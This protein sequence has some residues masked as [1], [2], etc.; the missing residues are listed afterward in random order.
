RTCSTIAST[1]EAANL[2]YLEN[3][4]LP[5]TADQEQWKAEVSS[6]VQTLI[7]P[8]PDVIVCCEAADKCIQDILQDIRAHVYDVRAF[9]VLEDDTISTALNYAALQRMDFNQILM[10][11]REELGLAGISQSP[12]VMALWTCP[13]YRAIQNEAHQY[14][15]ELF[16]LM[17]EVLVVSDWDRS[18]PK[19]GAFM[20]LSFYLFRTHAMPESAAA[21]TSAM[22]LLEAG[23][24]V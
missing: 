20:Y 1:A 12:E 21:W 19:A 23:F 10:D 14:S 11:V 17:K 24:R 2:V 15:R 5:Y 18:S 9:I 4:T 13:T 8:R 6:A 3:V 16:E 7:T 22:C